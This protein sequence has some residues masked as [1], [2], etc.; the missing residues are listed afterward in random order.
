LQQE[1]RMLAESHMT[2]QQEV[3]ILAQGQTVITDITKRILS[4]VDT[5]ADSQKDMS[6]QIKELSD[7]L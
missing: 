6:R 5:V 1:V 4:I 7:R 2:L 3:G